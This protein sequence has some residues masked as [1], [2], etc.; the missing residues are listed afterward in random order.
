MSTIRPCVITLALVA[1]IATDAF[2]GGNSE[3]K[4]SGAAAPSEL[5]WATSIQF[6]PE[7]RSEVDDL[8]RRS[9][10]FRAQYQRI[11]EA[12]SVVV[13]VRVDVSL[14]E[15]SYRA[16]TTFRRYQSGVIVAAVAI[17]PGPRRGEWIAHEF[18]HILEQ[19]DGR[20]LP[21]LASN[22]ANDVW[23]SGSDVIETDRAIRAGRAVRDELRLSQNTQ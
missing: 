9:P 4:H 8:L 14:C 3:K 6:A 2:A 18:E 16:R 17:G 23:Y 1:L 11:A 22:H 15:T 7:L 5:A 21:K 13:G 20:D 12:G 19:L 10:T